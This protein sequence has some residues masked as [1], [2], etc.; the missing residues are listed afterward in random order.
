MEAEPPPPLPP[1]PLAAPPLE[2]E[3]S[4]PSEGPSAAPAPST[5]TPGTW[6]AQPG[7]LP[8]LP[9][10][11]PRYAPAPVTDDAPPASQW[12]D[13]HPAGQWV[14]TT[15]Q[16]WIWIPA[17]TVTEDVDGVPYAYFYTPRVGWTWY[18]S[19]W[20]GGAYRYGGWVRHPWRP[21][22]WHGGWVAHPRVVVRLGGHRGHGRR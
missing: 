13:A 7:P 2:T 16:G 12:V 15:E 10:Q 22:G 19:P 17:G 5:A 4:A 6:Q 3:P 11:A 21:H 14:Y 8:P 20:G 1:P 18:V 9:S